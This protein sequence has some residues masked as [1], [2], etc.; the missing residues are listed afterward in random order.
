MVTWCVQDSVR[1]VTTAHHRN[2][3]LQYAIIYHITTVTQNRTPHFASLT[4][5][6]KIVRELKTLQEEGRAETLCY[7]LMS[8]HLHWLMQLR[9]GTLSDAVRLSKDAPHTQ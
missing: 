4:N 9:Q 6:R 7:V 3:T 1:Q 2:A 5:G 8:G